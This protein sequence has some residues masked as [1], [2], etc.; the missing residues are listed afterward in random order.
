MGTMPELPE[1]ETFKRFTDR[2]ALG[3]PIRA[4]RVLTPKILE[5][6]TEKAL[7]L[8]IQGHVFTETKRVGKHLLMG[9]RP[10]NNATNTAISGWLFLHFGMTGYLSY[11]RNGKT[12][13][14]AYGDP[15][16]PDAHI[17]VQFEG[18][19]GGLFNFHEQRMFGKLGLTDSADAY[20]AAKKLGP[21]ALDV[22][23]K[24]F[25]AR[26]QNRKGQLKPVLMDQSFVAGIGNVYA[27]EIMYQCRLHPEAKLAELNAQDFQCLHRQ[28]VE[29]LQNT[30]NVDSDRTQLP[31]HYLIHT[32]KAKGNCPQNHT[33]AVKTIGGRT[34][35]FCPACQ[36]L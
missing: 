17:R 31:S 23:E 9:L 5:N 15:T 25:L 33:L 16:R 2:Y 28:T 22:T 35:Y 21:D 30:V 4:V 12:I 3:Q 18:E 29:V 24:T 19:D 32:R 36:P 34:T 11:A 26:L 8:A 1:V 10:A 20:F 14:N 7:Q 6:T 13:A 27:D